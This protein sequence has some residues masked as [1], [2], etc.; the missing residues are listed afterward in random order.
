MVE[1][2]PIAI[3]KVIKSLKTIQVLPAHIC[4]VNFL[5]GCLVELACIASTYPA[6]SGQLVNHANTEFV[7]VPLVAEVLQLNCLSTAVSYSH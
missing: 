6:T 3:N 7:D 2:K 1:L 4:M 5:V